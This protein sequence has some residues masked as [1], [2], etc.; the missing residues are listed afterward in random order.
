MEI[1]SLKKQTPCM[2]MAGVRSIAIC[3]SEHVAVIER[4]GSVS[5]VLSA[6]GV[7]VDVDVRQGDVDYNGNAAD[8]C[9]FDNE[10]LCTLKGVSNKYDGHFGMMKQ[11]RWIVR[12]TD[13]CG[14]VWYVGTS[15]S[16][17]RFEWSVENVGGVGGQ[18][19]YK[20]RWW[21]RSRVPALTE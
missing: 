12:I 17:M 1:N 3:P 4:G 18:R 11:R 7:W 10:V 9:A 21:N 19:D 2:S 8:G 15:D 13:N 20:L 5:V 16:P 14:I 6:A